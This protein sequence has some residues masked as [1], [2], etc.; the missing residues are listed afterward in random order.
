MV[1]SALNRRK[2]ARGTVVLSEEDLWRTV[3]RKERL[4]PTSAIGIPSCGSSTSLPLPR[5]SSNSAFSFKVGFAE[6]DHG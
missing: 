4:S 2:T 6:W 3:S 1:E 5:V